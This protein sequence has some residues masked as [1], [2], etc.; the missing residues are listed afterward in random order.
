MDSLKFR[1]LEKED[2]NRVYLELL[3]QLTIIGNISN[4]KFNNIFDK[5]KT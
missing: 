4:E 1:L 5:I 2:Y 3:K